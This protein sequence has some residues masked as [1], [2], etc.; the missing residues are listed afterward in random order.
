MEEE[1]DGFP[2]GTEVSVTRRSRGQTYASPRSRVQTYAFFPP[3]LLG[4]WSLHVEKTSGL[5]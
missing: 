1:V 5:T 3:H 4:F 2:F